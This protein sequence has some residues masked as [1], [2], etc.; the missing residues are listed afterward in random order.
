MANV[1]VPAVAVT[2]GAPP[3]AFTTLGVAA[4]RRF[5]GAVG[6]T[7]LKVRPVRAGEPAGLLIV[8]VS[9]DV[10]PT[11][12]VAGLNALVSDG[13]GCTVRPEVVTALVTC[14][15]AVMLAAALLY[16]PPATLD[17]TFTAIVHKAWA[18]ESDA[19]V[20]VMV[21]LPPAAVTTPTPD[22]QLVVMVGAAATTTFAGSVSVK[23][24]PACAGL[25]ALLVIVK[26]SVEMPPMSIAVGLNALF[27]VACWT[28]SVWLVTAL[29]RTP[30]TV[31]CAAPLV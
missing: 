22:G 24:M 17:V 21:P 7:S 25:P 1:P 9:V 13:T 2:V 10:R 28:V 14:A 16:G 26:V 3:Q 27:S 19:P 30:P 4:I 15:V 5:A 11:P 18:A 6:S 8:K 29:V 23:L 12:I 20:T 31:T